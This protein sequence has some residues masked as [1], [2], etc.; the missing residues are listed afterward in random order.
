MTFA[1][2]MRIKIIQFLVSKAG[3]VLM[4]LISAAIAMGIA[5]L[6]KLIPG[7]EQSINQAQLTTVI[8]GLLM[9]GVNYATNRWLTKDAKT[10][11]EALNGKG[12]ALAVDG[13]V[14]PDTLD[15]IKK[16]TDLKV[17]KP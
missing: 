3:G 8:W 1:E 10:I 6:S 16:H 13:W 15:A 4:T 12:A 11:Q 5:R 9:S 2:T 17:Q 7:V 14:G